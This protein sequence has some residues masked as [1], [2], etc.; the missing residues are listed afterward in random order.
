MTHPMQSSTKDKF[1]YTDRVL[2]AGGPGGSGTQ[3]L[4]HAQV[5][6][7]LDRLAAHAGLSVSGLAKRAGLDPTTFNKSKRVTPD[8]RARW[9]STESIAKALGAT[10]TSFATFVQLTEDG[11]PSD[12]QAVPMMP[13]DRAAEPGRF[14]PE[15]APIGA[16]WDN[17]ALPTPDDQRA[18]ALSITGDTW[19]PVYRDGD[20]IVVSPAAAIRPGDRVVV[21][22]REGALMIADLKHQG[23]KTVELQE[24]NSDAERTLP[25]ADVLWIARIVWVTQ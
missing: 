18:F 25:G 24:I 20:M 4:T 23:G 8:G 14:D 3:P 19:R 12:P 17:A 9:P 21:K 11:S 16:D 10:G 5:W 6:S 15:G 1:L 7:A 22:T 13:V 2:P